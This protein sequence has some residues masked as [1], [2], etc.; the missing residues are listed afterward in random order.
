MGLLDISGMLPR[1][2]RVQWEYYGY[3]LIPWN[4]KGPPFIPG[5]SFPI[6]FPLGVSYMG[7]DG[8]VFPLGVSINSTNVCSLCIPIILG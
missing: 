5:P 6:I 3:G 8:V 7:V 4:F 1:N 2:V